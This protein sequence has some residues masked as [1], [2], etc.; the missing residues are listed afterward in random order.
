MSKNELTGALQRAVDAIDREIEDTEGELKRL[1]DARKAIL[2][3]ASTSV[4]NS[5]TD[6]YTVPSRSQ[7]TPHNVARHNDGT[8]TCNCTAA[9]HERDCWALK[10]LRVANWRGG[11]GSGWVYDE[12][13]KRYDYQWS[14][15]DFPNP[16]V[17]IRF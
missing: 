11:A 15:Y 5:I 16:K 1:R 8:W 10:A 6:Y 3:A 2:S 9:K 7:G 12:H 4:Q 14:R 17:K 13:L